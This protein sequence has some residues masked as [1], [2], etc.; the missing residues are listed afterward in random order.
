MGTEK[1]IYILC[2]RKLNNTF[3][4][5]YC[6]LKRKSC[7]ST[8][9]FPI[10]ISC[11]FKISSSQRCCWRFRSSGMPQLVVGP[12]VPYVPKITAPPKLESSNSRTSQTPWR[13][14]QYDLSNPRKHL[15]QRHSVT[16]R[17]I[18]ILYVRI[19]FKNFRI[20]CIKFHLVR[21]GKLRPH[22]QLAT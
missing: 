14:R 21:D 10:E 9:L 1:F 18:W 4:I 6:H 12:V 8:E 16:C 5:T 7:K 19:P 17:K 11:E 13:R 15:A 2:Y 22:M 3:V 20:F